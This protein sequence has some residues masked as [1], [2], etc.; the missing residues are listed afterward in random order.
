MRR[1]KSEHL[2]NLSMN[3]QT[4]KLRRE[5]MSYIYEAKK[6][7]N[8]KMPRITVRVTEN[9]HN[10]L[11]SARMRDN[12]IWIPATTL[13]GE[14]NKYLKEIVFHELCH[15]IWGIEHD[16]NCKLMSPV[17]ERV[18]NKKVVEIFLRYAKEYNK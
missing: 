14:T 13:K 12:I 11:A 17:L 15:A 9:R 5:V 7:L 4:Y 2:E 3:S 10:V 18:D 16:E 6:L 1:D 8:G